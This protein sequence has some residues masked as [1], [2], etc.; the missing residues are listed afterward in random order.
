MGGGA[1][2]QAVPATLCSLIE[3]LQKSGENMNLAF[4]TGRQT[5]RKDDEKGG[6]LLRRCKR[7]Q[8]APGILFGHVSQPVKEF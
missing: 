2:Q 7:A 3:Y 8:S 6:K 5:L 1:R 4:V